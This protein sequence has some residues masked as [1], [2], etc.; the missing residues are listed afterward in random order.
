MAPGEDGKP[1]KVYKLTQS[2]TIPTYLTLYIFGFLYQIVLVWDAL[3]LK[4]TIQVLG[5][6]MYDVGMLI[7][8]AIQ[9]D[10]INDVVNTLVQFDGIKETF[11]S[12]VHAYLVAVPCIIAFCGVLMGLIAWK[13]YGE[14]SWT[15][16]KHIS[17]DLRMKRRY[18]TYQVSFYS[19]VFAALHVWVD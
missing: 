17:A 11:W 12:E 9:M 10:Q 1:T 3:R 6:C 16:Y 4:N 19:A 8:S 7:Y 5:L 2:R 14:F 13:L 15:I 18:L